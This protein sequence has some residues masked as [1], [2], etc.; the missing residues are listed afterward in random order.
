MSVAAAKEL[1]GIS[2]AKVYRALL[3]Q[4]GTDA[5]VATVLE[6]T[7]GVDV[8][9]SYSSYGNYTGTANNAFPIDKY[10]AP[11]PISG[12]DAYANSTGGGDSYSYYRVSDNEIA[13]S[14]NDN[15][16]NNSPIEIIVYR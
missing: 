12:F 11:I 6:N 7:L 14:T 5:P 1:L 15:A 13:V 9:W 16:L 10:F 8:T 2:T 3:T 4:S